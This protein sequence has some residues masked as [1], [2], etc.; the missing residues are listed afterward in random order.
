MSITFPSGYTLF[1]I[2]N[3]GNTVEA[4]RSD[5]SPASVVKATITRKGATYNQGTKRFSV[6]QVEI[7]FTRGLREGDPLLPIPEQ[8]LAS[9]TF[10]EP[11]GH[12]DA[13]LNVFKDLVAMLN[14]DGMYANLVKQAIP[15]LHCED[16]GA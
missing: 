4:R 1:G 7:R 5:S 9:F 2:S 15:G 6:P 11:V 13:S 16:D 12:D 8:E 3:D 10:R 14:Q